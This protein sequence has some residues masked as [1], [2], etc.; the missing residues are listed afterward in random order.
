MSDVHV[1]HESV[2]GYHTV[3]VNNSALAVHVHVGYWAILSCYTLVHQFCKI[4]PHSFSGMG[5]AIG[6]DVPAYVTDS[7]SPA[8]A[9]NINIEGLRLR[10]FSA[11]AIRQ[12]RRAFKI[13]KR[14]RHTI[15]I[16]LQRNETMLRETPELQVLIDSVRASE[17]GIVR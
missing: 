12:L 1:G 15:D 3:L 6:K 10:G 4:G 17:R 8:E 9:K 2:I 7:G 16:A 13:D 14:Q 5:T 11:E